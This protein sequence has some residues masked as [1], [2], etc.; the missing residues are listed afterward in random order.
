MGNPNE[1]EIEILNRYQD[2]YRGA[3]RWKVQGLSLDDATK[4]LLPSDTSLLGIVKHLVGVEFYWY[5]VVINGQDDPMAG[6]EEDAAAEFRIEDGETINS[7]IARYDDSCRIS[8]D[9]LAERELTEMVQLR[10]EPTMIRDIVIHMIEETA[11]HAGHMDIIRELVDG[12]TGGF[13]PEGTP[14]S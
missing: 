1:T 6:A 2:A 5:Q 3:I 13:P 9:I 4:Q 7:L 10:G 11:R 14:W 8:R 12:Q